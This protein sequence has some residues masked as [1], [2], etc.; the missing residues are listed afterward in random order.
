MGCCP[1]TTVSVARTYTALYAEKTR[2][3]EVNYSIEPVKKTTSD[4]GDRQRSGCFRR[5]GKKKRKCW[6]R[7]LLSRSAEFVVGGD[8]PL[9]GESGYLCRPNKVTNMEQIR[10]SLCWFLAWADKMPDR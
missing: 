2:A 6:I 7:L 1:C 10:L 8:L 5:W 4:A 9:R 3:T